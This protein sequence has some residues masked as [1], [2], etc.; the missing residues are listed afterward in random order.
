MSEE[1]HLS[2]YHFVGNLDSM[3]LGLQD[4][5][6]LYFWSKSQVTQGAPGF[7]PGTS[8][9][10][11]KCSTPEL[12]PLVISICVSNIPWILF[13]PKELRIMWSWM[14]RL[15]SFRNCEK[16]P[17]RLISIQEFALGSMLGQPLTSSPYLAL[18]APMLFLYIR[19]SRYTAFLQ[20]LLLLKWSMKLVSDVTF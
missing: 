17:S 3:R 6:E 11:V 13:F 20:I 1:G 15:E 14:A 2:L 16:L 8:W 12:H 18:K 9:S 19:N 7:E 5:K 4:N 10:A